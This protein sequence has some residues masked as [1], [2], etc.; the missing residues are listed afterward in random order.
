[1]VFEHGEIREV[2]FIGGNKVVGVITIVSGDEIQAKRRKG[3]KVVV[4]L[5]G[6]SVSCIWLMFKLECKSATTFEHK[7]TVW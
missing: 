1:M 2:L 6:F 7:R 3:D 5:C 4:N